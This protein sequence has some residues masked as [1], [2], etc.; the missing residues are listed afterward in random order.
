MTVAP[1]CVEAKH[2][3]EG[4]TPEQRVRLREALARGDKEVLCNQEYAVV[5]S[6]WVREDATEESPVADNRI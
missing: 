5:V 1:C 4:V 2:E 6:Y 3:L